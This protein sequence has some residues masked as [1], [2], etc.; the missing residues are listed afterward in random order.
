MYPDHLRKEN[1][2][3]S[4]E[5]IVVVENAVKQY[6][7]KTG[8]LPIK[9]SDENTPVYEKYVIDFKRLLGRYIST[10]PA[11]AF[12]AGGSAYYVIIHPE[13]ELQVKLM[14]LAV[15]QQTIAVQKAVDAYA[16]SN[17]GKLPSGESVSEAFWQIDYRKLNMEPEYV[18][19][20]Y[21]PNMQL[22]FIIH[23]SGIVAVDYTSDLM[24][25]IDQNQLRDQLG[26]VKD[27]REL[28][29]EAHPYIPVKSFPYRWQEDRPVPVS[30]HQ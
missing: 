10:I 19:S 15:S 22:P 18:Q 23:Q 2:V 21:T 7:E 11:N 24:R 1:Q 12:E 25:H 26:D 14:N 3:P 5:Y 6:K 4:G 17:A 29:V 8:V 9:N 30:G 20:F 28:L 13:T 16:A 27:L